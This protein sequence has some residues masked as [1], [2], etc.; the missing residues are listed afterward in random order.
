MTQMQM[1]RRMRCNGSLIFKVREDN[2]QLFNNYSMEYAL[3]S[4]CIVIREQQGLSI[5]LLSDPLMK[6]TPPCVALDYKSIVIYRY[7]NTQ[8][9]IQIQ[10]QILL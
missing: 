10:T 6:T 5:P 4:L 7:T 8:I 2:D 9:Q 1:L 3:L